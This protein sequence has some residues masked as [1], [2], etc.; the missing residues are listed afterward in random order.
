MSRSRRK[1]YSNIVAFSHKAQRKMRNKSRRLI[2]LKSKKN[3][4]ALS[5]DPDTPY[6]GISFKDGYNE[7]SLPS[8]G[9]QKYLEK[10]VGE[11]PSNPRMTMEEWKEYKAYRNKIMRK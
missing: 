2:R 5:L 8:D 3:V 10:V 11:Y 1:P 6:E 4:R 7:W 9:H